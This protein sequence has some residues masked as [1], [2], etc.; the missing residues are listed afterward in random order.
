M[1]KSPNYIYL[2]D[3]NDTAKKYIKLRLLKIQGEMR[4][5]SRIVR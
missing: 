2:Y 4:E 1:I 3:P 5:R